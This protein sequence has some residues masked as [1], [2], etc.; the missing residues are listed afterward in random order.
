[1]EF[2]RKVVYI[3]KETITSL[4]T[5]FTLISG[6]VLVVSPT[7][8]EAY[9]GMIME[10][11]RITLIFVLFAISL[12]GAYSLIA[13]RIMD[14]MDRRANRKRIADKDIRNINV[15]HV[16][17]HIDSKDIRYMDANQIKQFFIGIRRSLTE[18][19]E[20]AKEVQKYEQETVTKA[21]TKETRDK[22]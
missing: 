20:V 8:A 15:P 10:L 5:I 21:K 11:P 9:K 4:T 1:V 2:S 3:V 14:R 16:S 6:I 22:K 17:I 18:Y 13:P 12:L 7:G 19:N